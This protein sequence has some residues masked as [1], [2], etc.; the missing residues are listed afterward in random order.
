MK[1]VLIAALVLVIA[2][3]AAGAADLKVAVLAPLSG[4]VPSFGLSTKEGAL[5]AIQEWNAK[6]GVLGMKIVPI[7]EDSQ[8]TPDPAVNAANKVINQDGVH[9]IIGEVCS[10]AS[11]PVSEIANAAKVVQISPTSTNPNV[12]ITKDGKTKEYIFR[13]CYIDPFQGGILASFSF[14]RLNAKRAFIMYDQGNDYTVGLANAFEAQFKKLGGTIVG[15]ETYT[16]KDADFSAILAKIKSANP[17]V[18]LLPDYYNIVN[19]VTKQAKEK[20]INVPFVGGDGWDSSDLDKA[21]AAGGFYTNHYA[22][23]DQRAEVQDFLKA[24]A[25]AYK[26]DNGKPKVPDALAVLAYDATNLL[27][28]GIK[29]AGKDDTSLVKSAV[30]K[31]TFNGVSGKIT[32]D[33]LH[34]PVKSLTILAVKPTAIVFDSVVQP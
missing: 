32:M 26:D 16:S 2:V 23:D 21:A 30:E 34:N 28:S 27:L 9:Y 13:A 5:L 18:V 25:K 8:C 29:A 12:T 22:P 19:L 24:Y 6:G 20:G 1:R 17:Q 15:K 33:K 4:P 7:V 10:S 3:L 14:G 11:I 31:I